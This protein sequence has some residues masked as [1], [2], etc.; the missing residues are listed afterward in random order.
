YD[1]HNIWLDYIELYNIGDGDLGDKGVSLSRVRGGL[2]SNTIAHDN[3]SDSF[4]TG[5]QN[6]HPCEKCGFVDDTA[7][8]SLRVSAANDQMLFLGCVSCFVVR[9]KSY[10]ADRRGL[11][12]GEVGGG[13]DQILTVRESEFYD[14]G[15]SSD[16]LG[17]F[18]SGPCVSGDDDS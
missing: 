13:F 12:Y 7:Y 18:Q 16:N 10:H 14:N 1:N 9:A 15:W 6:D 11:N 3:H 4:N 2:V 5:W 17:I 8:S